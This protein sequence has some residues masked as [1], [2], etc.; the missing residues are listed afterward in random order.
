MKPCRPCINLYIKSFSG[1]TNTVV[2]SLWKSISW[3][4][5]RSAAPFS[6]QLVGGSSQ[7]KT[8]FFFISNAF[9]NSDSVFLN[10][11][12]NW[13]SNVASVLLNTYKHHHTETILIFYYMPRPRNISCP[14]DL[15]FIFI[16]IFTVINHVVSW[17]RTHFFFFGIR[18][19][20]LQK[21]NLRVL[22]SISL[23]WRCL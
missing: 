20:I 6:H 4:V 16:I 10:F 5:E 19:I 17:I 22:L 15:F 7:R 9:C 2:I 1:S 18:P 21:F 3:M 14:C 12:I 11:L 8:H 23:H 13:P